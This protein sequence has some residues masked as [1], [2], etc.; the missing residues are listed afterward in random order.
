M[1]RVVFNQKGEGNPPSLA[2]WPPSARRAGD[3]PCWWIWTRRPTPRYLLGNALDEQ[4]TLAHFFDDILAYKLFPDKPDAYVASTP[5]PKL[6]VLPSDPRLEELQLKL[7]SCHKMYKL[8][9]ALDTLK[10]FDDIFID[11]PPALNF[12]TRSALIAAD[13]LPDSLRLRRFLLSRPVHPDGQR[14]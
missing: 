3:A 1:R 7:E 8:R 2:T 10:E 11:T 13:T 14:P 6:S 12:Y 4:K 9:E 5:F